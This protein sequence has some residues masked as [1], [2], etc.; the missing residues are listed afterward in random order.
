MKLAL[1]APQGVLCAGVILYVVCLWGDCPQLTDKGYFLAVLVLGVFTVL[2]YQRLSGKEKDEGRFAGLCR[3]V[4]LL[5][6]GL[7]LVGIWNLPL[8]LTEKGLSVL[9]WFAA[10]YGAARWR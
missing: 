7:M 9:A 1:K 6:T 10:M 8:S 5:A 2:T 3:F 4:L